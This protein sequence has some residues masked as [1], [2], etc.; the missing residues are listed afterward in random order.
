M[1][2]SSSQLMEGVALDSYSSVSFRIIVTETVFEIRLVW[3]HRICHFHT[4]LESLANF[5]NLLSLTKL[6]LEMCYDL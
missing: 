2:L 3:L 5:L 4:D 1:V 6:G